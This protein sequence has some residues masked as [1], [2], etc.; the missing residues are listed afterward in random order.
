MYDVRKM[1]IYLSTRNQ[2]LWSCSRIQDMAL[3]DAKV[4]ARYSVFGL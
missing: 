1:S 3:W 2:D 4:F